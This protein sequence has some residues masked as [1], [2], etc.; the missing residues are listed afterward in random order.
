MNNK[1]NK[2]MSS[3]RTIPKKPKKREGMKWV[4][5]GEGLIRRVA[6]FRNDSGI[7]ASRLIRKLLE[8][9][10]NE[11]EGKIR[12]PTLKETLMKEFL[13]CDKEKRKLKKDIEYI[14]NK[15]SVGERRDELTDFLSPRRKNRRVNE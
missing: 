4:Q 2:I 9:F 7:P 10:L 11:Y 1:M 3:L 12:R 14:Y 8:D 13:H 15:K 6:F 5:L